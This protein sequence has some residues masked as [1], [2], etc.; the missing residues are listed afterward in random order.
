MVPL[1]GRNCVGVGRRGGAKFCVFGRNPCVVWRQVWVNERIL[2]KRTEKKIDP[3]LKKIW[4][5][6]QSA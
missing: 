3:K 5:Y 6:I 4:Y 2:R 1:F